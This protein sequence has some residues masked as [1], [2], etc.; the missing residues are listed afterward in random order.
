[1]PAAPNLNVWSVDLFSET[2]SSLIA[3]PQSLVFQN[4]DL[5]PQSAQKNNSKKAMIVFRLLYSRT[6]PSSSSTRF[7][8]KGDLPSRGLLPCNNWKFDRHLSWDTWNFPNPFLSTFRSWRR[9]MN[10]RLWM[11]RQDNVDAGDLYI[12]AIDTDR[13]NERYDADAVAQGL[14]YTD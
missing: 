11:V 14:R 10:W 6:W 2:S 12:V 4:G 1:M 3:L 9:I 7:N 5:S 8:L 13:V